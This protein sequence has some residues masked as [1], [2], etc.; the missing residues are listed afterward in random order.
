MTRG[1]NV[2]LSTFNF[3]PSTHSP[4]SPPTPPHT[5]AREAAPLHKLISATSASLRLKIL[6]RIIRVSR[7]WQEMCRRLPMPGKSPR[8]SSNDWNFQK[9]S[10]SRS[11]RR[12]APPS[13]D[14]L[15]RIFMPHPWRVELR[16]T[17]FRTFVGGIND[18]NFRKAT[19]AQPPMDELVR[20]H[21]DTR[22]QRP[23]TASAAA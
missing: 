5:P 3:Q 6:P 14:G 22:P 20:P 19:N 4:R 9:M 1:F 17:V 12:G 18:W 13:S 10:F 2:Q 8:K 11:R 15:A 16:E 21:P 23:I 7:R